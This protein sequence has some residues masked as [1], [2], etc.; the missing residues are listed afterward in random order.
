M[1]GLAPGQ[2][3]PGPLDDAE[4]SDAW[5]PRARALEKKLGTMTFSEIKSLYRAC[6]RFRSTL[7]NVLV[8]RSATIAMENMM[9]SC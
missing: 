1:F 6:P 8:L 2:T 7:I 4:E 9:R 3:G 5:I